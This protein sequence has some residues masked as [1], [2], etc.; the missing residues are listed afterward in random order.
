MS[1]TLDKII[2]AFN[3]YEA[4]RLIGR[5]LEWKW[6]SEQEEKF[7]RLGREHQDLMTMENIFKIAEELANAKQ[8]SLNN[9]K[10]VLRYRRLGIEYLRRLGDPTPALTIKNDIRDPEM[11]KDSLIGPKDSDPLA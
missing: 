1:E 5:G 2:E 11:F 3:Q 7:Y 4:M 8:L 10:D 6:S 9:A